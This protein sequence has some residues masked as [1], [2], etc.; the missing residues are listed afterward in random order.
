MRPSDRRTDG[1]ARPVMW[2]LEQLHNNSY[3]NK[4]RVSFMAVSARHSG[5]W[6]LDL[7]ISSCGLQ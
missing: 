2:L 6:L 1:R 7:P 5:D 4:Q 3:N